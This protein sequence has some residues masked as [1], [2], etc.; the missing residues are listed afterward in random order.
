MTTDH[1]RKI[2]P[3]SRPETLKNKSETTQQRERRNPSASEQAQTCWNLACCVIHSFF[4]VLFEQSLLFEV[5]LSSM[6]CFVQRKDMTKQRELG[7]F[8]FEIE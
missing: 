4:L 2:H 5:P 8:I 1:A 3:K 7:L 6:C